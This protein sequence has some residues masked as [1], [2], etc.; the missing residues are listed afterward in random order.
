MMIVKTKYWGEINVLEED[1]LTIPKGLLGFEEYTKFI[2]LPNEKDPNF[3]WLQS[4]ENSFLCFLAT[5]PVSFMFDY[6]I[7]ISDETVEN[8]QIKSPD[9]VLIYCLVTIPEDPLQISANLAGPLVF[10][11][12]TRVG[13]QIVVM[14]PKY[15]VK[16][17]IIDELKSNASRVIDNITSTLMGNNYNV[18]EN[19]T[20]NSDML[21]EVTTQTENEL[22]Q[23]NVM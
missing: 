12:N 20:I 5:T 9:D 14:D 23:Y 22:A 1:I 2:M 6:S 10:N 16:H 19:E 7:E 11:I 21:S 17:F 8:L 4:I 15:K 3:A 13:E 18:L